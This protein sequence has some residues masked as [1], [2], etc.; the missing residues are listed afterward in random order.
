MNYIIEDRGRI[1]SPLVPLVSSR[2]IKSF[3]TPPSNP[4]DNENLFPN[5]DLQTTQRPLF[6]INNGDLQ[7]LKSA[8]KQLEKILTYLNSPKL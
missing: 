7:P 6:T 4:L 2:E 1:M 3:R 8:K 5:E